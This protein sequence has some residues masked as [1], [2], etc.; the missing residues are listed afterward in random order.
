M[1]FSA[2][3]RFFQKCCLQQH[4]IAV[5][6]PRGWHGSQN[7]QSRNALQ[8][9]AYQEQLLRG[10][11]GES[12]NEDYIAH[13][14]NMG[15][16]KVDTTARSYYVDGYDKTTRTI[17]EFHGCL[18][19][20]CLKYHG[21]NRHAVSKPHPERTVHEVYEATARNTAFLYMTPGVHCSRAMGM[22]LG[23]ACE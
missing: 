4:T 6:P 20:G 9:L 7:N 16:Q 12:L 15:E 1:R 3:I 11:T 21:L 13:A 5:E 17:Y 8:W 18:F 10:K 23:H 19:H 22:R 14:G 2:C